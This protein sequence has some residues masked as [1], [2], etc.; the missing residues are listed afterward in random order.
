MNLY[1]KVDNWL[2]K[3][4]QQ[5]NGHLSEEMQKKLESAVDENRGLKMVLSDTQTNITLLRAELGQIRNQ[6]E[7]KCSELSE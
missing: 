4:K 2:S 5:S 1:L 3:E 7:N 6:Y